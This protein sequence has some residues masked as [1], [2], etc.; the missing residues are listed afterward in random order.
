MGSGKIPYGERLDYFIAQQKERFNKPEFKEKILEALLR[1]NRDEREQDY[2]ELIELISSNLELKYLDVGSNSLVFE[3]NEDYVIKFSKEL[4]LIMWLL[5][6][7][8]LA[9]PY[10]Q[11]IDDR[12]SSYCGVEIYEKMICPLK[13]ELC[14]DGIEAA[15]AFDGI[16]VPIDNYGA[17]MIS[18]KTGFLQIVDNEGATWEDACFTEE[19]F[20]YYKFWN[21]KDENFTIEE[22]EE[23]I[24]ESLYFP[25]FIKMKK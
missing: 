13:Y 11:F 15:L 10:I 21:D 16:V 22:C 17:Y 1:A 2:E 5:R 12:S 23:E 6:S 14:T 3:L 4:N 19:D 20:E 8:Y 18:P 25:E 9:R 7:N 24:K